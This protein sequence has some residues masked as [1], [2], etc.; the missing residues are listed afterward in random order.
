MNLSRG[1]LGI[2]VLGLPILGLA[3]EV[4]SVPSS[5]LG[6]A[7]TSAVTTDA[8]WEN[9][10]NFLESEIKRVG[11]GKLNLER[12]KKEAARPEAVYDPAIDKRPAD[13]V[14]RRTVALLK[15]LQTKA[16]DNASLQNAEKALSDWKT[17]RPSIAGRAGEY[18]H[19][20]ALCAIRR[21][22]TFANPLLNFDKMLFLTHYTQRQGKGEVHMVDQYFGFNAKPGGNIWM[23]ENPFSDSAM[24]RPMFAE[25]PLSNGRQ[26]GKTLADGSF[27]SLELSY[28]ASKIY[29]AW[30]E[31]HNNIVDDK[32]DWST[33]PWTY[34]ESR[35]RPA[36]YHHY[37]LD[38][39]R[40]YHLYSA[41]LKTG[42]LKQLTD[43]KLNDID[44]VELPNGRIVFISERIDGNARCGARWSATSTLHSMLPDGSDMYPISYHETTEWHPSV[45]N[46]G[47]LVYSRWDYVDR[48]NLVAHHMWQC[49]P[50]GRDP[51]SNHGNYPSVRVNR[52]CAELSIRAIPNS[53]KF[54]AVSAPHHGVAFGSLI[55]IDVNTP[56]DNAMSQ[57]RR[58]TPET[59][60]PETESEPGVSNPDHTVGGHYPEN[61]GSP[62]PLDEDFNICVYDRNGRNHGIY[63]VD[64]FGN[65]ELIWH[66]PAVPCLDPIPFAP[67]VRPP[68]I[69]DMTFQAAASRD[70]GTPAPTDGEVLILN[71]YEGERPVSKDVKVKWLRIV[72]LFP[73]S[74][75]YVDEPRVSVAIESLARGSL[76]LVPVEDDGSVYFKMPAGINV[77]FQLLDENKRAVQSMKSATYLHAGERLS[78]IG[79]HE[80]K[81][82]APMNLNMQTVKALTRAPSL[83]APEPIGGYPMA[84]PRLVQPVL[85]KNCVACHD[86]NPKAPVLNGDV[87]YVQKDK[88]GKAV[89]KTQHYGWSN[90]YAALSRF[91]WGKHGGNGTMLPR[92]GGCYS[93][94][95][96]VGAYA[97]KLFPML[98]KGHHEVKLTDDEMYRLTLWLDLNSNF[99][100]SYDDVEA[101]RRGELVLPRLGLPAG[102]AVYISPK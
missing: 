55:T 84:Y 1:V 36:G 20:K 43:G 23:L 97:S 52:P 95:G 58:L 96:Q 38:S 89:E 70:P 12:L 98:Q 18:A 15:H 73:K 57:V 26:K 80:S 79:C 50:D 64:A 5:A 61:Y 92:N 78:C 48:D 72:N 93:V 24:A 8:E 69:P 62:W 39:D 81:S 94:P 49:Y 91:A 76:G 2:A 13:I 102:H 101:Q 9:E 19:F 60:F 71:V 34:A 45:T 11:E 51:R 35:R 10:F 41:D 21:K 99:L 32:A 37:Y 90:S 85:D 30:T 83:P 27:L 33:Q 63:V 87:R 3:A 4:P 74:N 86:K 17:A 6:K 100:G 44:P 67:R 7:V 22:I 46:R 42:E 28:D 88:D 75:V 56:D 53:S 68:V 14:Y 31:A 40:V 16:P 77:Y 59:K 66:D 25:T 54:V 65:R 82:N 47:A 29:F